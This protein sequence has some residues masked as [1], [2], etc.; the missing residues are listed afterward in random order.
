MSESADAMRLVWWIPVEFWQAVFDQEESMP[1]EQKDDFINIFRQYT[2]FAI[3][4]GAIGPFGDVSY[5]PKDETYKSLILT[6]TNMKQYKALENIEVNDQTKDM[7]S[8]MKPVLSQMLGPMGENM[9]FFFFADVQNPGLP[10]LEASKKGKFT[11]TLD[12]EEFY[13]ELPLSSLVAEKKCPVD[14]ALM[15]GTWKYCPYHANELVEQ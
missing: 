9:H 11:I 1:Q 8:F 2:L 14:G 12:K 4:D 3:L 13:W 15:N 5:A 7:I 10:L 6:A